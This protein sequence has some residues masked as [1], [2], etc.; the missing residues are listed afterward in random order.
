MEDENATVLLNEHRKKKKKKTPYNALSTFILSYIAYT[1]MMY[2]CLLF[3]SS[4]FTRAAIGRMVP[5][6]PG[7]IQSFFL[8]KGRFSLPMLLALVESDISS[9]T[10]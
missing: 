5:Y 1:C 3:S 7:P 2:T 6:E 10:D 8:L 4:S 9:D